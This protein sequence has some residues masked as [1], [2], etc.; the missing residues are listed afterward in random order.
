MH[1]A[2]ILTNVIIHFINANIIS[3]FLEENALR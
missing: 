2:I 3:A 1:Q